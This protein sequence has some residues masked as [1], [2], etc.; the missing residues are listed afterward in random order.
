MGDTSD[1]GRA[2]VSRARAGRLVALVAVA[3]AVGCAAYEI[4]APGG[5]VSLR[6][7]GDT[8]R[9]A[10]GDTARVRALPLDR[11]GSLLVNVP[12][13]WRSSAESVVS[14][15]SIGTIIARIPG[16][17]VVTA[18]V[19]D[20][21]A[22]ATVLVRDIPAT[23]EKIA[24]DG[25]SGTSGFA[26]PV[27]PRVRVRGTTGSPLAGVEVSF[28]VAGGGGVLLEPLTVVTDADGEAS[29][30]A[31]QLGAAIADNSLTATV[32]GAGVAG[33]PATFTATATAGHPAAA[34]SGVVASTDTI[35]ASSGS[36]QATITVTV[37][38]SLGNPA[39]G[40]PVT[41]SASGSAV[42]VIQPFALTDGQGRTSGFVSATL[43]GTKLITAQVGGTLVI[44]S[45][46]TVTVVPGAPASLQRV[47]G[48]AQFAQ[49]NTEVTVTPR[50][51]VLDEFGTPVPGV[52]VTYS[53]ASG[54]GSVSEPAA[55]TTDVNGEA[56]PGG[57]ILGTMT[58]ANTLSATVA[59]GD[60]NGS[61][62]LFSATATAGGPN[63]QR[64]GLVAAPATIAASSGTVSS[65]LTVVVRDSFG[66]AVPGVAVALVATGTGISLTQP[67]GVTDSS[68]RIS[69]SLSATLPG[70]KLV[71]A[72]VAGAVNVDS[73]ATVIVTPGT[74]A[75][76]VA[77]EG[78][79]QSAAVNTA[80]AVAPR[81]RVTDA[82][83]SGVPN[84]SVTFEVTAGGGNVA[85]PS[86][87]LTDTIGEAVVGD[88]VLGSTPGPNALTATV[89][90]IGITG[91]PVM[92]TA[93]AT[94]GAPSA[95][96]SGLSASPTTVV[97]STGTLQSTITVRIRDALGNPIPGASVSLAA[98]GSGNVVVQPSGPTD[99]DGV[100]IG[101]LSSSTAGT[102]VV[103]AV[104]NGTVTL[105]STASIDFV[106][107]APVSVSLL[108]G[109][110]QTARLNS[111][112]AVAPAVRVLGE[113]GLP[114]PGV[115]V[116][117][118]V[119]GGGG[120][121]LAPAVVLTD[122]FGEAR[123]GGW[124]LG[125]AEGENTLTATVAG[126]GIS[127]NPVQ[128]SATATIGV[129][130]AT[131][132]GLS[133]AP[134]SITASNGSSQTT[135]SARVRDE[136]GL[137][138]EGVTVQFFASGSGNTLLQPAGL[139]DADG[140][141]TGT[142]SST[143][144]ETK[145]I[146]AIAAGTILLDS[147]AAV[148][149]TPGAPASVVLVAGDNQS[150]T[151]GTSVPILPSV[152]VLDAFGTAVPGVQ[153]TF[154][155]TAGGGSVSAPAAVFTD[156]TGEA[157]AGGWVLGTAA[158]TNTLSATVA[159]DGVSGNPVVFT[160]EAA[161]GPV[162][163]S[164]S[165]V[166]ASPTAITA[167]TGSN[168]STIS[169]TVRDA[170]GNPIPGRT[171]SLA[172]TGTGNA[173][174]QPALVSDAL[175]VATG[176]ISSTVAATKTISATVDGSV[177]LA[178]TPTVTVTAAAANRLALVQAPAGAVA[179]QAF[180]TQPVVEVQDTFG[181]RVTT[182]TNVVTVNATAGDGGLVRTSAGANTRAAVAGVV[183]WSDLRIRGPR[184]DGDTLGTGNHTIQFSATGL[185]SVS[186]SINVEAS[187]SY[188]VQFLLRLRYRSDSLSTSGCTACHGSSTPID[189]YQFLVN[190]RPSTTGCYANAARRRVVAGD[191]TNSTLY[192]LVRTQTPVCAASMP[193][194][195]TSGGTL[196]STR[197]REIIRLWILQGA[198]NN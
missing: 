90:G 125:G 94:A 168:R 97:T 109:N 116:A 175:G 143:A 174:T 111:T 99:A 190:Y 160:A 102:K 112:V 124:R 41:L 47:A 165:L 30:G 21:E 76:V 122:S 64:S 58:G 70:E 20:L 42:S 136:N 55:V 187:F 186:S 173:L 83:G 17:A 10:V 72:L 189:S 12:V 184:T 100:A 182:A 39:A 191:P 43:P 178:Q 154:A 1:S 133:A 140:V 192:E 74:P 9:L 135:L 146:T 24:G 197:L 164:N 13:E 63:G 121:V 33:N 80:V 104:A 93:T 46:A 54:G 141:A 67:S 149:V 132:S 98:S 81:V 40:V 110:G 105:D 115:Q 7:P 171:V 103:S 78:S 119:T 152:R 86:N 155:A 180:T 158:G 3:V 8:V 157:R 130:N 138:V 95:A 139:T 120:S 23:L 183:N 163:Q 69:G 62:I 159:G 88:W 11:S 170:F 48:D 161:P 150:A 181:N 145:V 60:V 22:T 6:L 14:V 25:Q 5:V 57:W 166:T 185:L 73:T 156:G 87:V 68:G 96:V 151:V 101:T 49:V 137:P 114:V 196:W 169:V 144:S 134:A 61:P 27:T 177:V 56:S 162:S 92:F 36:E 117:F 32:V 142:L 198:R 53:V 126:E 129:P 107:G 29:P 84:I 128:F 45:T 167:S 2:L 195:T 108:E 194:V 75:A 118:T 176:S 15:D 44:D 123:P 77:L 172:A 19:S 131:R 91:N 147:S 65:E 50:T 188:N 59:G 79:G 16:A 85:S 52:R 148:V 127:G 193:S 31:W 18:R 179:N 35:A 34:T 89:A 82:F 38:D 4:T 66:N 71:S 26:L 28:A 113:G 37:R 51:R 153:V 106:A